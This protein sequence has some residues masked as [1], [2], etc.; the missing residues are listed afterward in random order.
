MQETDKD[1]INFHVELSN[2]ALI[3]EEGLIYLCNRRDHIYKLAGTLQKTGRAYKSR[4]HL[5]IGQRN[6]I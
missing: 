1:P 4:N 6:V 2:K 5:D 3:T